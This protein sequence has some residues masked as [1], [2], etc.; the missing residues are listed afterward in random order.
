MRLMKRTIAALAVLLTI[1]S[2]AYAELDCV[3]PTREEGYEASRPGAEAIRRTA[4]A[5]EAIVKRNKL[6]MDGNEPVRVRTSISH[7][8]DGYASASVITTAYNK[9]AWVA[10]EGCQISKFCDRGGGLS[11]GQIAVYINDPGAM[12][13]GRMGDSKLI[14]SLGARQVGELAGYPLYQRGDDSADT[15]VMM[16]SAKGFPWVPVTIAEALD[17]RK[18]EIAEREAS[19]QKQSAKAGSG[20]AQLR[21][22]AANKS[23]P[24]KIRLL[25]IPQ[26]SVK[27]DEDHQWQVA[28][29]NALDYAAIGALLDDR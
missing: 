10:G 3:V 12:L 28:S 21:N 19:W 5:I 22:P 20:E 14:A 11:D 4:R 13:G 25:V 29:R 7:Y 26:Y 17:W 8:G 6:F 15:S 1:P 23:D 2:L 27:T 16:S 18:R 9:K 24:A